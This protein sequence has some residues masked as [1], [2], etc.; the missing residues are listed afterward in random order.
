[1]AV[2]C[3]QHFF[4]EPPA[5][6]TMKI[7]KKQLIL[8]LAALSSLRPCLADSNAVIDLNNTGVKALNDKKWQL[9]FD[10]LNEA[11]KLDPGYYLAKDN[12]VI[13][14]NLYGEELTTAH[15]PAEALKQFH[16]AVYLRN[17][18][19]RSTEYSTPEQHI[20]DLIKAMGKNPRSFADRA[21]LG[22]R[23]K[24]EGDLD[25]AAVEYDAAV[26][27]K[28]DPEIHK[29]L[30]DIYRSLGETDKAAAEDKEAGKP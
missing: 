3:S 12:L 9:A 17:K 24:S 30:G 23:A 2:K 6:T 16:E 8:I 21:A 25:G 28:N 27:L 29:K 7:F 14:H 22:D 20:D 1:L 13:A 26:H 10:K 11:L 15:K 19:R 18:W 4:V 5:N